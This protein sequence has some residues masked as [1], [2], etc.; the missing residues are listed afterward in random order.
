MDIEIREVEGLT[1]EWI[2][3]EGAYHENGASL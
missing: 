1:A 2:Y 3:D